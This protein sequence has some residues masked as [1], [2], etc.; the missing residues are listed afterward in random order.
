MSR[1][2]NVEVKL[3]TKWTLLRV[4][5]RHADALHHVKENSGERYPLRVVRIVRTIVF[6]AED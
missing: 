1:Y 4:F 2:Y 5:T 6:S 3:G